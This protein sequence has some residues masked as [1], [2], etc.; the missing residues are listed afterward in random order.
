MAAAF[1]ELVDD[2]AGTRER[3]VEPLQGEV[4][5]GYVPEEDGHVANVRRRVRS[6]LLALQH[7]RIEIVRRLEVC[8]RD[9]QSAAPAQPPKLVLPQHAVLRPTSGERV[10]RAGRRGPA[11]GRAHDVGLVEVLAGRKPGAD[12]PR[13]E[14]ERVRG[15]AQDVRHLVADEGCAHNARL[16]DGAVAFRPRRAHRF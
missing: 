15:L 12:L 10:G 5:D 9:T 7:P 11:V 1:R 6:R 13:G 16:E 3:R 2:D 8:G 14:V 4:L